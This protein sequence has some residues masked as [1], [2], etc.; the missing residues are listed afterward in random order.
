MYHAE[1]CSDTTLPVSRLV[2]ASEPNEDWTVE[3]VYQWFYLRSI[4]SM[5][6]KF[7]TKEDGLRNE[8]KQ[9]AM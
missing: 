1:Q 4:L 8:F 6:E 5:D 7:E 2:C 3:E 9:A